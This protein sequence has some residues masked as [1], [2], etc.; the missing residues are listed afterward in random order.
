MR[1][2]QS[3]LQ[4]FQ[5]AF[6]GILYCLSHERNM[7]IHMAAAFVAGGLAWRLQL[8][9]Y[10]IAVLLLTIS[11]VLLAEMV[12]TV[13]E[14]VVDLVSP[15]AHPLAK[16]AKDAAAGAVLLTVIISLF[17]GYILFWDKI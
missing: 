4:A 16:I 2:K 17:I 3:L 7:K 5:N 11:S 10:E 14:T 6:S 1:K 12:N 9:R 13:V 15:E 8:D